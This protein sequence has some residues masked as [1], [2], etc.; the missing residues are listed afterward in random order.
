MNDFTAEE[1]ILMQKI[2]NGHSNLVDSIQ[3]KLSILH[4]KECNHNFV[5]SSASHWGYTYKH[6]SS[7]G[8]TE[9]VAK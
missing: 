7:C 1:F 5:P 4:E 8:E 6:C 3:K 2:L 9:G